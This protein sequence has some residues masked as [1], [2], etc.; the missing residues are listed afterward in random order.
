VGIN[1]LP[2]FVQIPFQSITTDDNWEA[3][4]GAVIVLGNAWWLVLKVYKDL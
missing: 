3:N 4:G 1:S 2:L